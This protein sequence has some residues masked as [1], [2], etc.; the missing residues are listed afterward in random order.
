[1][2]RTGIINNPNAS[3]R[4]DPSIL[5][6]HSEYSAESKPLY[7]LL[8]TDTS[9]NVNSPELYMV[10]Y[11]DDN[12]YNHSNSLSAN[13][14]NKLNFTPE[15][16]NLNNSF[17]SINSPEEP[18]DK[19][20]FPNIS[21]DS[22]SYL[23]YVQN[24]NSESLRPSTPTASALLNRLKAYKKLN[25]S[26][27][28]E[29]D[30]NGTKI[31]FTANKYNAG[32]SV[33]S[34]NTRQSIKS[35]DDFYCIENARFRF[36]KSKISPTETINSQ[37]SNL[38]P[39]KF[40]N[41]NLDFTQ[42]SDIESNRQSVDD[43][44]ICSHSSAMAVPLYQNN[45]KYNQN[46]L[47]NSSSKNFSD[48]PI[49]LEIDK[50]I[51]P[52]VSSNNTKVFGKT[53]SRPKPLKIENDFSIDK[54]TTKSSIFN[55]SI[56]FDDNNVYSSESAQNKSNPVLP[57][58][59]SSIKTP[60]LKKE[61]IKRFGVLAPSQN[62]IKILSYCLSPDFIGL[63]GLQI[64]FDVTKLKNASK[65]TFFNNYS[66]KIYTKLSNL[67][68][69]AKSFLFG[70]GCTEWPLN[71]SSLSNEIIL[72]SQ[73][74]LQQ[75]RNG[76]N[77][78]DY[79]TDSYREILY[80]NCKGLS[81]WAFILNLT[82]KSGRPSTQMINKLLSSFR[83]FIH[84]IDLLRL[85]IV[86]YLNCE[87]E[88]GTLNASDDNNELFSAMSYDQ[89]KTFEIV[90]L[91][92][93]NIIKHWLKYYKEDFQEFYHLKLLLLEF[94]NYIKSHPSKYKFAIGME[95][96]LL[97]ESLFKLN[98]FD[99]PTI[100]ENIHSTQK[101]KRESTEHTLSSCSPKTSTFPIKPDFDP[102]LL[103]DDR[104]VYEKTLTSEL[105]RKN[106]VKTLKSF[107][108]S[109]K[110]QNYINNNESKSEFDIKHDIIK[111]KTSKSNLLSYFKNKDRSIDNNELSD[112]TEAQKK[113]S[114]MFK[115][116]QFLHFNRNLSND[117]YLYQEKP[118]KSS[119]N[120]QFTIDTQLKEN[121]EFRKNSFP[122]KTSPKAYQ[123]LGEIPEIENDV[124]FPDTC[125]D[126]K[127]N[128]LHESYS[129]NLNDDN[130]YK[131]IIY[132]DPGLLA[133]VLTLIEYKYYK[134]ITPTEI[135][136]RI[137][138]LV[139]TSNFINAVILDKSELAELSP[140]SENDM[141]S[142]V[143]HDS[144]IL[145]LNYQ[146]KNDTPNITALANWSNCTTHWAV[147]SV[148]SE[149]KP[150]DRANMIA[151][152]THVAY[153]CL[154][155]RNYNS[156][157]GLIG[158]LTCSSISRLKSTWALVPSQ[159]KAI[160]KQIQEIWT[161]RPNH[162]LYRESFFAS[163][164]GGLGPDYNLI[165][166]P[167]P[168][169]IYLDQNAKLDIDST[170][171]ANN[172]KEIKKNKPRNG[173]VSGVKSFLKIRA[174]KDPNSVYNY[175]QKS[176]NTLLTAQATFSPSNASNLIKNNFI[177]KASN[178]NSQNSYE[179][180][181]QTPFILGSDTTLYEKDIIKE[182]GILPLNTPKVKRSLIDTFNSIENSREDLS[183]L[184][185][186]FSLA[187][188]DHINR[189][190]LIRNK[191]V[192]GRLR[193]STNKAS[194]NN[195]KKDKLKAYSL[196]TSKNSTSNVFQYFDSKSNE[197]NRLFGNFTNDAMSPLLAF[198]NGNVQESLKNVDD[199]NKDTPSLNQ[200]YT[201]TISLKSP[202]IPFF[203][204]H[205]K[206]LLYADEANNSYIESGDLYQN[207]SNVLSFKNA[208][209]ALPSPKKIQLKSS[210][211]GLRLESKSNGQYE[212][213]SKLKSFKSS[214]NLKPSVFIEAP[215]QTI[216]SMTKFRIVSNILSEIRDS[217]ELS[218][219][220]NFS[221]SLEEW[222]KNSILNVKNQI[223]YLCNENN[224]E[225]D[226]KIMNDIY[227]SSMNNDEKASPIEFE[228]FSQSYENSI[229][230]AR[231]EKSSPNSI[232]MQS[233][234]NNQHA[235]PSRDRNSSSTDIP[236]RFS[237]H[238]GEYKL[239][240]A[241]FKALQYND[242]HQKTQ[243]FTKTNLKYKN[244]VND[245]TLKLESLNPS[246]N[247]KK[248]D[249]LN[250]LNKNFEFE[251][252]DSNKPKTAIININTDLETILY[253]IS[254]VLE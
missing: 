109:S 126:S 236:A 147:Y 88:S 110:L 160:I 242:T 52:I 6:N 97:N 16:L 217:Q 168:D 241:F 19:A 9:S 214:T 114:K 111:S 33:S 119:R 219:N 67:D 94:L 120:F 178:R 123:I 251:S 70:K 208:H 28:N 13:D 230:S 175:N 235:S 180:S 248:T 196:Q 51:Q 7:Q 41:S 199:S 56:K 249:S 86:R 85:L 26:R 173:S 183:Q 237:A 75:R 79:T 232:V 211:Q 47:S 207:F 4:H 17:W 149:K 229:L 163:L 50:L 202:V 234:S 157:F 143:K 205:L 187:D 209:S 155:L 81:L 69:N 245:N 72:G 102:N 80:S 135:S 228:Y 185:R 220:F 194:D 254:K 53:K 243:Y 130:A 200:Y 32:N 42:S 252:N 98:S 2:N 49:F 84:P 148:L 247:K 100:S 169:F 189:A 184:K 154:A 186:A 63:L 8:K 153:Y 165:F 89:N 99:L 129:D 38:T 167:Q 30:S 140:K 113:N 162:K 92:T 93:I 44:F 172:N 127:N 59:Y 128:N 118:P 107:Q 12:Y 27:S 96:R 250:N 78:V 60:S 216:M 82:D 210:F 5:F 31:K 25:G 105:K 139:N 121:I 231:S 124:V 101:Q 104:S 112:V 136:K 246:S 226:R 11:E 204:L 131:S 76:K 74:H 43:N 195:K 238:S 213:N 58:S 45:K 83:F 46:T 222:L 150:S 198:N 161:A 158:G 108:S 95:F 40:K 151:H 22:A 54:S 197:N 170:P 159:F 125:L 174:T 48:D 21:A 171:N 191:T 3:P 29:F 227:S 1:M 218:Y 193:S 152:I 39:Y 90:Q 138:P 73:L 133:E 141:P 192:N 225:A 233:L 24:G 201:N 37:E 36:S 77:A 68:F 182:L 134:K 23:S 221:K 62:Y 146:N 206:D 166:N 64:D 177:N 66:D 215:N 181:G 224:I 106:S 179:N 61:K 253:N 57:E 176:E 116:D 190:R 132:F 239:D 117:N 144:K 20:S 203:G 223:I 14:P 122:A 55:Y 103:S 240:Q 212:Q 188:I 142:D 91:R 87:I 15:S 145:T 137:S 35:Q 10:Q 115:V 244:Q 18:F 71:N 34:L 156:A 65:A 164:M